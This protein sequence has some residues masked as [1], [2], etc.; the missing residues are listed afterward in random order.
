MNT[1]EMAKL[2]RRIAKKSVIINMDN[3][4]NGTKKNRMC[5]MGFYR[6]MHQKEYEK[7]D[8]GCGFVFEFAKKGL[9]LTQRQAENL[10]CPEGFS[11]GEL[12]FKEQ[13]A[14]LLKVM[15]GKIKLN[16]NWLMNPTP[17]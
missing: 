5:A 9:G 8:D 16:S 12:P 10:F 13:K 15:R 4:G 6:A 1:I 11:Y 7:Q 14:R 17:V 3:A 2:A